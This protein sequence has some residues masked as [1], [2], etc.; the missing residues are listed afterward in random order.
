MAS[1]ITCPVGHD[2]IVRAGFVRSR[3]G[4]RQRYKC[5][6]CGRIFTKKSEREYQ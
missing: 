1:G 6:I 5:M 3:T 4:R 2:Y